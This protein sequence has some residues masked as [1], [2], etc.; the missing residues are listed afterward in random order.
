M[1]V[2]TVERKRFNAYHQETTL[3]DTNGKV[4]AFM[5]SMLNQPRK[6]TKTIVINQKTYLLDWSNVE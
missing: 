5:G 4:K 2:L 3:K 1:Q 6:G